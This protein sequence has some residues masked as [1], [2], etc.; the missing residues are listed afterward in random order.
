M[1]KRAFSGLGYHITKINVESKRRRA[2]IVMNSIEKAT[3]C[4]KKFD[5]PC[6]EVEFLL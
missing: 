1:L 5:H 6:M 2:I 4:V 3:E